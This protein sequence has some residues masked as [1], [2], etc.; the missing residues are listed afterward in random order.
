M[1]TKQFSVLLDDSRETATIVGLTK[2][3]LVIGST[4]LNDLRRLMLMFVRSLKP[5]RNHTKDG[6]LRATPRQAQS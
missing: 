6:H 3:P 1:Q 4:E 2:R 5:I